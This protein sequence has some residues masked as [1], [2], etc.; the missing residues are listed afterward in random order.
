MTTTPKKFSDYKPDGHLWIT[1]STGEYYPDILPL[2]CELYKPVLVT[3]GHLLAQAHSS[4]NLLMSISL[5]SEQW[6]RIQLARVFRKYV[7]PETPVE[8]LKKKRA[9]QSICDQF[10]HGFRVIT[11]VQKHFGERPLYRMKPYARSSGNTRTG[12]RRAMT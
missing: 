11:E 1:L 3:F 6:M 8:M 5:I 2:A 9:A 4:V 12:A 10:G 7:S